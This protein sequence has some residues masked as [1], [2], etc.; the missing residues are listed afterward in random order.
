MPVGITLAVAAGKAVEDSRP[1]H[2]TGTAEVGS[3]RQPAC[4]DLLTL[5]QLRPDLLPAELR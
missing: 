5:I 3:H 4:A 2:T 1:L